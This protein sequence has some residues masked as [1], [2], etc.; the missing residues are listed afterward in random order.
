MDNIFPPLQ[1]IAI[2]C[3]VII[4]VYTVYLIRIDKLSAHLAVSWIMTEL[5]LGAFLC[6]KQLPL[7]FMQILGK[8]YTY[9][10]TFLFV[11]GWI[12]LLMLDTLTRV[13]ALT[14]K[15]RSVIEENGLLR[16]RVERLE[17]II[18][19]SGN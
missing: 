14:D 9:P 15:T 16:E 1:M 5:F 11:V 4:F 19:K 13:S 8:D 2:A 10:I 3:T 18:G 6:I 7:L 17:E 12:I